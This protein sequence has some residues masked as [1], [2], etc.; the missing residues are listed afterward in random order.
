MRFF[1]SRF[2]LTLFKALTLLTSNSYQKKKKENLLKKAVFIH[3]FKLEGRKNPSP[4]KTLVKFLWKFPLI[5]RKQFGKRKKYKLLMIASVRNINRDRYWH[6]FYEIQYS[7][8]S[9]RPEV[10]L[11]KIFLRIFG[12]LTGKNLYRSLSS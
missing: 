6:H 1:C 8:R 3:L 2:Y 9:S 10:Y 4:R 12:K 5:S 11:K 7:F